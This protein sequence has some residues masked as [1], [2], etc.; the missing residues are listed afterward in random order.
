M[1]TARINKI[2]VNM[3]SILPAYTIKLMT[4]DIDAILIDD[5]PLI[6]AMWEFSALKN[7]KK[8]LSFHSTCEFFEHIS[9]H[10]ITCIEQVNLYIDSNLGNNLKGEVIA[11]EIY[12]SGYRTIYLITGNNKETFPRELY[13]IKDILGKEPPW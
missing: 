4:P 10:S 1:V 8:I 6:H 9:T 7:D 3:Q 13:W 2:H 5:D 11:K 12:E